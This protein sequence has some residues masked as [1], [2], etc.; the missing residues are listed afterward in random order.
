MYRFSTS[1]NSAGDVLA[2]GI[3][4]VTPLG[5]GREISWQRLLQGHRAGR[6]LDESQLT[7]FHE[8]AA[9]LKTHPSGAAVDHSDVQAMVS[10]HLASELPEHSALYRQHFQHDCLNNM[11]A[12][13]LLE[14][15][16]DAGLTLSSLS[17]QRVGCVV[18]TSKASLR[19]MEDQV[20]LFRM[21]SVSAGRRQD[22]DCRWQN[23]FLPDAPLRCARFLTGAEGPADCPVAACA[24]G[25]ISVIQAAQYISTGQCDICIAGSADASLRTSVMSAFHRLGVL[26]RH[27]DPASA[28]RPFD[29]D[30]DGFIIGEGAAIIVLESRR[31]ADRRNAAVY[32]QLDCGGW[33]TDPTGMTQVDSHGTV[34]A[35]LL[36]QL[37]SGRVAPDLISLHGTATETNDLAE[38]RGIRRVLGERVPVCFGVKGAVG[39]LLGAAGSVELGLTLLSLRDQVIPVTANHQVPDPKCGIPLAGQTATSAVNSALKLSLGFGGHI[40]GC[41]VRR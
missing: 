11:I 3:G 40:A 23:A 39:H 31:H 9:L 35:D 41:N 36:R 19:A 32:G 14:A 6:Q 10:Q 21:S 33:M 22:N 17:E 8:L 15:C 13:C 7:H 24:T 26:S 27:P 38:A 12:F 4:L 25:L 37:T 16:H 34:V 18:G 20:R 28:C 2:T 30:R 1:Q 5:I 29:R